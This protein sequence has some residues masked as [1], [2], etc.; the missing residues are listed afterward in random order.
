MAKE[1]WTTTR[2]LLERMGGGVWVNEGP[3][4][5]CGDPKNY[6]VSLKQDGVRDGGC[7]VEPC[8]CEAFEG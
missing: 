2:L 7:R 5:R 3:A 8:V 6:H 4:C 1:D